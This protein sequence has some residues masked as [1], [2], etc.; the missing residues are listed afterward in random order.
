[1]N[2]MPKAV[3][4]D[5]YHTLIRVGPAPFDA[6]E[7]WQRLWVASGARDPCPTLEQFSA[8]CRG[9][10]DEEHLR[11]RSLGVPYPEVVWP[12]IIGRALPSLARLDCSSRDEWIGAHQSCLRTVDLAP[13]AVAVL[14]AL[15]Q[16]GVALG[17]ASNAQAYTLRELEATLAGS[18][19]GLQQFDDTLVVW[20]YACGFSKPDPHFFRILSARLAHRG[21]AESGVLMV[22]DRMDN[23]IL[24]ARAIGWQTWQLSDFA[25]P[26]DGGTWD[27]LAATL[28]SLKM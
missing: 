22:G 7:R 27:A 17:I 14:S 6:S 21:V 3:I 12:E 1:M 20:S 28:A 24:P 23:D 4:F 8:R 15:H 16:S 5:V 11:A 9:F 26:D 13:G 25:K 10:V 2:T 18:P 19:I